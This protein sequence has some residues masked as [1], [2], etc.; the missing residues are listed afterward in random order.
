MTNEIA[1]E[2]VYPEID[3]G[4]Y[5][6]KKSLGDKMEVY[7]DIFK[8]GHDLIHSVLK[9]R[10]QG[11]SEWVTR[12]MRQLEDDRW[13]GDFVMDEIGMYEYTIEA[14]VD[15][16]F[17]YVHNIESWFA[18]GES[19]EGD[20]SRVAEILQLAM[21][22]GSESEAYTISGAIEA[23]KKMGTYEIISKLKEDKLHEIVN[24]YQ[25]RAG[26]SSY[27]VLRVFCDRKRSTF[28]AWYELFPRSQGSINSKSGT[29]RDVEDRLD[30]IKQMGFDVLYLT[31]IHPIGITNRRGKNGSRNCLPEDVGSPWAIGNWDGGHLAIN[32]DLGTMDDF[33]HLIAE[34]RKRDIEIAMDLAFQCSPDHPYVR[35][36][37]EWFAHGPDGRIRYAENPP[38]KY[39]DIYPLDFRTSDK[40]S[41]YRELKRIVLFWIDKGIRIFRVDNPHT[42]PFDFWDFLINDIKAEYPE[43][44]F[45]SE[46]FTRRK[47]MY[48]LSK[49]G[50]SMSYTYFTWRNY[51][52]EIVEYFNELSSPALT[53][54][55]RPMLF[56][57]T[58]D[59][60]PS[61]LS[62]KNR[63]AFIIRSVLASTLSPLWGIY[64]GFELCENT[65]LGN[66]EEY[67]DSE[68][69]E[70]RKRDW[71]QPGNIKDIISRLN[72]IRR[73]SSALQNLGN[74]KFCRNSNH[75]ILAYV[76]YSNDLKDILIIAVNLNPDET[77]SDVI[78][79]PF[80]DLGMDMGVY[81]VLDLL[82]GSEYEW[83]GNRNYVRLIPGVRQAHIF[84]VVL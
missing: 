17:T 78:M 63:N 30:D 54:F 22:K 76:R 27:R 39:Y 28:S 41:L 3:C 51:D 59:I 45:L 81:K 44:I 50:F 80:A 83:S 40:D 43:T 9:Y 82:D 23:I 29:F 55:F 53:P 1:I 26:F 6:S 57:N 61:S 60:I 75:N 67:Q 21:K 11:M 56:T 5:Y 10:R 31:P 71:N 66:T 58:P 49:I 46:A 70:I 35:E 34:A 33:M 32:R 52:Y 25:E 36:H 64:S 20:L 37:P 13:G 84:K 14:W 68:K 7:A 69:Y 47:V 8:G 19:V 48:E 12:S 79:I 24:R 73:D 15:T 74:L 77:H 62:G 72:M 38:K 65:S 18:A 16:Y 42:K 4:R 2:N